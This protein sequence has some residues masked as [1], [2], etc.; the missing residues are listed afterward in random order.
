MKWAFKNC[1][2]FRRFL[3]LTGCYC[4]G[5]MLFFFYFTGKTVH[6]IVHWY[7]FFLNIHIQDSS[8][9]LILTSLKYIQKYFTHFSSNWNLIQI[10]DQ[11]KRSLITLVTYE[12]IKTNTTGRR[13]SSAHGATGVKTK[14]KFLHN[15]LAQLNRLSVVFR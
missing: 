6:F 8:F 7:I 14:Q 13:I 5:K 9:T 10:H 3:P 2:V 1:C 15:F 11:K 4:L 12:Q